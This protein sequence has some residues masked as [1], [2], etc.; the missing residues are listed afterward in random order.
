M[1]FMW[2]QNPTPTPGKV[3]QP[4]QQQSPSPQK[5]TTN[6]QHSTDQFPLVVKVLPS[7]KTQAESDQETQD[8]NDKA[9]SERRGLYL[10]GFLA[11]IALFQLV[12]YGYQSYKLKQTVDSAAEQSRAVERHIG[13]AARSADAME[14]IASKIDSGNKAVMRAYLTVVIGDPIYQERRPG[15]SDLKF[16]GRPQLINTGNTQARR[17]RVRVDAAVLPNPIPDDFNFVLPELAPG[18]GDQTVGAHQGYVMGGVV[19][20]F[21]PDAEVASIKEGVGKC[22]CVWGLVTY[23][24]IF[25][26]S[27]T[28]NFGQQITWLPNGK[29]FGYYIPAQNDAD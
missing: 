20:D 16:E 23:Q 24:D 12:V 18:V 5:P 8:R 27:H 15:Q 19:K 2:S 29:A 28:T 14:A 11:L 1:L 25:G 13:E 10:T 21:V 22:L 9:A 26:D 7:T 6:D 3:Q 17:V 4:E